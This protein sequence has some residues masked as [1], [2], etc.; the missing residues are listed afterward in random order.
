MSEIYEHGNFGSARVI[1]FT[2]S[3]PLSDVGDTTTKLYTLRCQVAAEN[4]S[5]PF[6]LATMSSALNA[7]VIEL[8]AIRVIR[9]ARV[10]L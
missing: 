1:D 9:Q 3:K 10:G 6:D 2:V 7:R 4:Y 5:S 8:L